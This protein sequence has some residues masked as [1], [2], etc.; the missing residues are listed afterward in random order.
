[1]SARNLRPTTTEELAYNKHPYYIAAHEPPVPPAKGLGLLI[2]DVA[3]LLRRRIDQ[4]AQAVGLTS[5][6]WRVLA[7]LARCEGRNQANLAD[8]MDM[9]PITLCR[10]LD[11]MEAAGHDRAP[12]RSGRPA[13]LPPL[14]DRAGPLAGRRLPRGASSCHARDGR[15]RRPS[16]DRH[17]DRLLARMRIRTNLT[18]KT[19]GEPLVADDQIQAKEPR[20]M[21]ADGAG[22]RSSR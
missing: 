5:A 14:S 22:T 19:D 3:R 13:R 4:Q 1:M 15:R 9:E 12:P 17:D 21:S 2:H 18:G 11:R 20:C 16:R 6:Q 8:L 7:Y 10:Q